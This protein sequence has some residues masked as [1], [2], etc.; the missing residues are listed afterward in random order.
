MKIL[1][2]YKMTQSLHQNTNG[3][4]FT[5]FEPFNFLSTGTKS[6]SDMRIAFATA[7]V[8]QIT[9]QKID[10]LILLIHYSTF[11]ILLRSNIVANDLDG[12]LVCCLVLLLRKL[13]HGFVSLPVC[14]K[15]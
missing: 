1:K 14:K 5:L 13:C 8:L 3:A 11:S 6:M 2:L 4:K 10:S 15:L 9:K 7:D 12:K